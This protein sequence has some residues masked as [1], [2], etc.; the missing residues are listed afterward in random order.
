[1]GSSD[2]KVPVSDE[3]IKLGLSNGKVIGNI[4]GNVYRITIIIDVGTYLGSLDGAFDGSNYGNI[5]G[6]FLIDP[7]GYTGGKVLGSDKGI[8]LG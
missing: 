3:V 8:K 1:M 6:L 4:L 7:L 5:E 2:G